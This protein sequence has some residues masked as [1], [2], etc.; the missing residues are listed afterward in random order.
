MGLNTAQARRL[1]YRK[2]LKKKFGANIRAWVPFSSYPLIMNFDHANVS[3]GDSDTDLAAS[4]Y[5]SLAWGGANPAVQVD[6]YSALD[7]VSADAYDYGYWSE[8]GATS[9][10]SAGIGCTV[11]AGKGITPSDGEVFRMEVIAAQ[12]GVYRIWGDAMDPTASEGVRF[13]LQGLNLT[14]DTATG[15]SFTNKVSAAHGIS[16]IVTS[17]PLIIRCEINLSTLAYQIRVDEFG[18][19]STR[20]SGWKT[21]T[22][23]SPT[24]N[25][26]TEWRRFR[27]YGQSQFAGEFQ[28]LQM[29]VDN[30]STAWPGGAPRTHN[31]VE[32]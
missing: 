19:V 18:K 22:I 14:I 25:V 11:D 5:Y 2:I 7:E 9:W 8:T 6:G 12:S 27:V 28:A 30:A 21:G 29:W 3:E 26:N 20:N 17:S 4:H 1:L 16:G 32:A 24:Y 31:F 23:A 15:G 13:A 10:A